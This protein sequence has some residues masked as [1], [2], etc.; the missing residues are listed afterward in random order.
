LGGLSKKGF[1]LNNLAA[2]ATRPH[3]TLDA[4]ALLF[5]HSNIN[6]RQLEQEKMTAATIVE[7]YNLIGYDAV[8]VGSQDLVAG[9]PYLTVL[10]KAAKFAWLSANLVQKSTKKPLFKP[11][12]SI[13]IGGIK[14]GVIGLTGPSVLETT[15]D[16]IILPW[17]QVLPGLVAKM[18]KDNELIILLSNLPAADNQQIAADYPAIPLII[19]SGA[20]ANSISPEPI[21]NTLVV[22]TAP[23]GKHV[24]ILEISW[25]PSRHWGNPKTAVL[26]NKKVSL[27]RLLWE[28]SKYQQDKDPETALR[29]QPEQLKA[30]HILR[31]QEQELRGEIEQLIKEIDKQGSPKSEPSTYSNR[32]I[33]MESDTP[34]H[35]EISHL[36]ANLDAAVNKLGQR[37]A[38]STSVQANSPYLG[39]RGCGTCHPKQMASWQQT[40]HAKAYTTL[41]K[42]NQQFNQS[43]LPCHVTGIEITQAAESLALP[44]DRRGVG[45]ETCHGSGRRHSESPKANPL[46]HRPGPEVCLTCHTT[47]HDKKFDYDKRIQMIRHN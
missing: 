35:P 26:A 30:Y 29:N 2:L 43:C 6:P 40:E 33:A 24:G 12:T 16:A 46:S 25:Q 3:L 15:D 9:L 7:A 23:Q 38:E 39:F 20:S 17:D 5:K 37:Q 36:I 44:D 42:G 27:D 28:L 14:A 31:T 1:Q 22:N 18:A 10:N 34:D 13:K 19:Q 4:G 32:F 45:C 11:S 8:C 41:E 47:P 21:N